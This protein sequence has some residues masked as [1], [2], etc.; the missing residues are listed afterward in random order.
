MGE[1][2]GYAMTLAPFDVAK[3]LVVQMTEHGKTLDIGRNLSDRP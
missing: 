2:N 3:D 1:A